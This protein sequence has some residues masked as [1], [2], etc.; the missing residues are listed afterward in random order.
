MNNFHRLGLAGLVALTLS[1]CGTAPM[2]AP[3]VTE[4]QTQVEAKDAADMT[5]LFEE[6]HASGT[7]VFKIYQNRFEIW[8]K[9]FFGKWKVVATVPVAN[10]VNVEAKGGVLTAKK[11][12][13][14][15]KNGNQW[16]WPL[17]QNLRAREVLM[18]LLK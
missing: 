8:E 17:A 18:G 11:I 10:I 6:V 14:H 13:L 9:G 16:E 15:Y 2:V 7:Y 4:K 12:V 5:P 3:T 1:G